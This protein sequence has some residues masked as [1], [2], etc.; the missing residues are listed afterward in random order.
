MQILKHRGDFV[1]IDTIHSHLIW[2]FEDASEPGPRMFGWT[3]DTQYY[4]L[5]EL[6]DYQRIVPTRA[7]I[8]EYRDWEEYRTTFSKYDTDVEYVKYCDE[9]SK[10]I[11]WV[12]VYLTQEYQRVHQTYKE[13]GA[14]QAK[15]IAAGFSHLPLSLATRGYEEYLWDLRCKLELKDYIHAAFE[16]WKHMIKQE[17]SFEDALKQTLSE[18]VFHYPS[19]IEAKIEGCGPIYLDFKSC[20]DHV[21]VIKDDE[22]MK[23]LI[24]NLV[25]KAISS[26]RQ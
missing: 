21:P 19:R 17:M 26:N 16:V 4:H 13:R 25:N 8:S 1:V 9:I 11:K 3:I 2:E 12:E 15:K 14:R 6:N 23:L 5:S 7:N 18:N 24:T 20:M 10:K 22:T